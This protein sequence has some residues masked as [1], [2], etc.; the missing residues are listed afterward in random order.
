MTLAVG[1]KGS[2][3][4]RSLGKPCRPCDWR[5]K[6][7]KTEREG[8]LFLVFVTELLVIKISPE[9]TWQQDEEALSVL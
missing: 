3:G 9:L 2:R 8:M 5:R 1:S 7:R 6:R 4:W